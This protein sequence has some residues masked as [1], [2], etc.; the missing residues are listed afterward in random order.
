[1][2]VLI[3]Y[4]R[5][6]AVMLLEKNINNNCSCGHRDYRDFKQTTTATATKTGKKTKELFGRTITQHVRFRTLYIS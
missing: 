1:M 3:Q 5:F 6:D 4:E 2:A